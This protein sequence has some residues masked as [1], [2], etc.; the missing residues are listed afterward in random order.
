MRPTNQLT[1]LAPERVK[2]RQSSSNTVLF[3]EPTKEKM[4]VKIQ[5][6]GQNDQGA[7]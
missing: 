7:K 4:Q 3:F 6:K 5:I 1:A 2:P